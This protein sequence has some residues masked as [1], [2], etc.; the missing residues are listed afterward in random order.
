M[1]YLIRS[2]KPVLLGGGQDLLRW[3]DSGG[4]VDRHLALQRL[5]QG[6][7]AFWFE[8]H[9]EITARQCATIT[10]P[11]KMVFIVG[12]WR[13][14]STVLHRL[15]T[16]ATGWATPRTWQCF[17]P[18]DFLLAPAPR[19]R[20]ESRPMDEGLVGTFTPQEDEFA[21]LLI[22]ERSLYRAF[23][24]PRRLDELT[25]LLYQWKS[26]DPAAPPLSG[27]WEIFLKAVSQGRPGPLL[28]K[29]PNHTFRLPWLASRFPEAQFVWLTR[30][31][32]DVLPSNWRM[33]SAM[34]QR[35]GLWQ[36]EARFLE[37]FLENAIKSHDEIFESAQATLSE[38]IHVVTFEEVMGAD[39]RV[40]SRL[41]EEL[42]G[43]LVNGNA[44]SCSPP[45]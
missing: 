42:D 31:K 44:P 5:R 40:V 35:Y 39:S 30:P 14:G 9:A 45:G 27:R 20:Q 37:T 18:A 36:A 22:G 3:I 17:R 41:L 8:R 23:I 13:S 15:L 21:A 32:K 28:L 43:R 29:S 34:I 12:L 25:D 4:P 19:A 16:D 7:A 24:D 33:W 10:L 26:L 38:R 6:W 1:S 2:T 11:T